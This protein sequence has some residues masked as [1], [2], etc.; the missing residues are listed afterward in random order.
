MLEEIRQCGRPVGLKPSGG[1]R[2]AGD[3]ANYLQLAD[4]IMGP[5]WASRNTFRFG[6]SSLLGSLIDILGADPHQPASGH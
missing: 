1:I 5:R 2:T 4:E 3:A 6:A